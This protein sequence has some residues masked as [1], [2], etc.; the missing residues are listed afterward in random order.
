MTILNGKPEAA[1]ILLLVL[2]TALVCSSGCTVPPLFGGGATEEVNL[3]VP[4]TPGTALFVQNRNGDVH[5]TT[6][7]MS[8]VSISAVK[9][10]PLA[11]EELSLV[12]IIVREEEPL[13]VE[14]V[15][16]RDTVQ[17]SVD[18][19]IRIPASVAVDTVSTTNGD[20][21]LAG[22]GGDARLITS[23]GN[24]TATGAGVVLARTS[25]GQVAVTDTTGDLA[26]TSTNGGITLRNVTGYV[27]AVTSNA[28]IAIQNP[29]G[30]DTIR[31]TNARIS[32]DIPAIRDNV[33]VTTSNG[34]IRL[35]I[36][37]DLNATIVAGTSGGRIVATDLPIT[38]EETGETTLQG[39]L[40]SGGATITILTS[41]GDI[42]LSPLP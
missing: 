26:A 1:A 13:R 18:E 25:N 41:N 2:T 29:G 6:G 17:V 14:T 34:D 37:P 9:Q 39:R 15:R 31:S 10:T 8:A 28:E 5:L 22:T 30:I 33:S 20:I 38:V 7:N 36:A 24:I 21:V 3:T 11:Q 32:A 42:V 35:K 19:R 23:N 27:S 40:G 16:A 12:E 4:V